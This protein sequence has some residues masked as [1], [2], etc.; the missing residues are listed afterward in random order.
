MLTS[1]IGSCFDVI[2]KFWKFCFAAGIVGN[3]LISSCQF[4]R[5]FLGS[6]DLHY[7]LLI[8]IT[9]FFCIGLIDNNICRF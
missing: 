2:V 9:S 5:G 6:F 1:F 8:I 3:T 4:R 7:D